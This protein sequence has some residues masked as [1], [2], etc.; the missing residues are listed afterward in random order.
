MNKE[1]LIQQITRI[2]C[3]DKTIVTH[4]T[5]LRVDNSVKRSQEKGRVSSEEGRVKV[6][7]VQ[8]SAKRRHAG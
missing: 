8:Y 3:F 5:L 1:I 6:D 4:S 2:M 7:L